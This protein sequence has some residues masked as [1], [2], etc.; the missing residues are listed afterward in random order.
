M[1]A[2][3]LVL[4]VVAGSGGAATAGSSTFTDTPNDG[5]GGPDVGA[6]TVSND[7]AGRLTFGV[8][9]SNRVQ[10]GTNE[11]VGV[12]I[13]ADRNAS[14][15]S[16]PGQL[17]I[18]YLLFSY[19]TPDPFCGLFAW[20]N[21]QF[22]L[23]SSS[24]LSCSHGQGVEVLSI[25][26][27]DIAGTTAFRFFVES[28]SVQPDN[29]VLYDVAPDSVSTSSGLWEY[30]VEAPPP[31]LPQQTGVLDTASTEPPAEPP[32]PVGRVLVQVA[33]NGTVVRTGSARGLAGLLDGPP[34]VGQ[35]DCGTKS[36]ECYEETSPGAQIG[37]RATPDPG[38]Q[39]AGWSGACS[40]KDP[41][42]TVAASAAS[43]ASATF[44]PAKRPPAKL[45]LRAP[46]LSARWKASVGTGT[47]LL[48]GS[49]T[50]AA[51][52]R[53]ELR[54]PQGA[55]LL[56]R[57]LARKPGGFSVPVRLP[58]RLAGGAH[59]L[60]GGFV[61]VVRGTAKGTSLPFALRTV[62]LS[63]PAEG[64]VRDTS[65]SASQGGASIPRL[66][67]GATQAWVSFQFATQ[68]RRGPITVTWHQ[69]NGR[70][71]GK[72][73][74]NNRPVISTGIGAAGGLAPGSYRVDLA[75]GGHI[76]RRAVARIG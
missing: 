20:S 25:D 55:P 73:Q 33:G 54:R 44:V 52:L 32:Q 2:A 49:L 4:L 6:T 45:S 14:T 17:G 10:L 13:D 50:A 36:Y 24:S 59:L 67:H 11:G 35:I 64:V 30:G 38:Y 60:P 37:M 56:V 19:Y 58:A 62:A 5:N 75:A 51:R 31:P 57:S 65:L 43:N 27:A 68:P 23:V 29:N 46:G 15:G 3:A 47:L 53:V 74:K 48:R 42:C 41:T 63:G 76:V 12:A 28:F 8:G 69:P 61:V 34:G 70:T 9:F 26:K 39:F 40:G 72:R 66:E 16:A 21:G 7:S 71:L 1:A 22:N 18:D